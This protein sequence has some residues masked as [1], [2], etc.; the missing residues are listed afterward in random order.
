[1]TLG[2]LPSSREINNP[3]MRPIG[4]R[5]ARRAYDKALHATAARLWGEALAANSKLGDDRQN[6]VR[7]NAALAGCRQGKDDPPLDEAARTRLRNHALD[8]LKAELAA[9]SKVLESGP[10]QAGTL[11]TKDLVHW[12]LD[13]DL[14]GI[15]DDAALAGRPEEERTAF[16]QFWADVDVLLTKAKASK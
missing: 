5:S 10:P 4:W 15:R 7:Y 16:Q 1:M 11:V 14:A 3:P 13:Q 9:W 2:C 8:W 6:F 12:Q